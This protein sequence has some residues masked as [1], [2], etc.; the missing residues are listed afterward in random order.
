MTCQSGMPTAAATAI[1]DMLDHCAR[2][3]P[4]EEILILAQVDGLHGGDNMV[5]E[6]AVDWIQSCVHSR[7]AHASVLWIDE[8]VT[9]HAWRFPP[10]VK[11]AMLGCDTLINTSFDLV[12]EE[13]LE[14]RAFIA[15]HKIKMVRNFATTSALLCTKWAQTPQEVLS[16]IRYQASRPFVPGQPYVLTDE[17]GTHLEGIVSNSD[18][19]YGPPDMPYSTR[20]E[21]D[22]YYLPWPEWVHPP[23]N[24]LET[25]GVFIFDAMLSW[26]SRYM[27]LPPYLENPIELVVENSRIVDIKG[28]DEAEALRRFLAEMEQK[29]GELVYEFSVFHFGV[30]PYAEV[31]PHEC[32][33]ILHR[34]VI[35]HSHSSNIH[36]HI[37]SAPANENYPYWMHATADIRKPTLKV[38]DTLVH[39]RGHLLALDHPGVK[40]V[41]EKYPGRPS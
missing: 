9:P 31:S 15:E 18:K 38:G 25:S 1:Y 20:R 33:N 36:A 40:A 21:E 3:K 14:F 7:G 27:G 19:D 22:G 17:N 37:G 28:K 2:V 34:R 26:W 6:D 12:V 13:N 4:G 24:T 29:V 30:H 8:P 32:P 16:E 11:A 39:D 23:V 35:E 10:I 5:D 41:A